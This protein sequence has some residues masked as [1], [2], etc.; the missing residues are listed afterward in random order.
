MNFQCYKKLTENNNDPNKNFLESTKFIP[1]NLLYCK[2]LRFM[3][4]EKLSYK[5]IQGFNYDS[6]D[7]LIKKFSKIILESN[8]KEFKKIYDKH[9]KECFI[10]NILDNSQIEILIKEN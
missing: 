7:E 2:L 4:E 6:E 1:N 9:F 10:I 3:E 5:I 8:I